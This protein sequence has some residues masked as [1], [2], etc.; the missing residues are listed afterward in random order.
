MA[1]ISICSNSISKVGDICYGLAIAIDKRG[2]QV[3]T[4]NLALD[5]PLF[6]P[7]AHAHGLNLHA[8]KS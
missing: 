4:W 2:H 7:E 1:A 3:F 5:C 8:A 6:T